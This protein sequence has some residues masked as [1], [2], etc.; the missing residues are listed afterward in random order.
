MRHGENFA[1]G[2]ALDYFFDVPAGLLVRVEED[3]HFRNPSKQIV[4]VTHDVLISA[5]HENAEI[6][7]FAGVNPMKGQS[8]P[9][10]QQI[11]ELG[12]LPVGGVG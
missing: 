7:D 6:V 11:D 3:M 4:K 8:I 9:H 1:D 12:D 5:D 2:A 10:V